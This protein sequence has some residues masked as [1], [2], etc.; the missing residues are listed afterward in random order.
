[1]ERDQGNMYV[2]EGIIISMIL[3]GAA[4][5]VQSLDSSSLENVRPRAEIG[6]LIDDALTVL[7][8]LDDGSGTRLLDRYLL[9]AM[10]CAYD[11]TPSTTDCELRRSKNLSIKLDSYLPLGGGYSIAL[12]NG[13]AVREIY[14]S[15]LPQGEAVGASRNFGPEWNTT[16]L[17]TEMSCYPA[18]TDV[19]A[20]LIPIAHGNLTYA[21]WANLTIGGVEYEGENASSARWWNATLAAGTRPVAGN[22]A[23]NVT[24]NDSLH[25][26]T[27]YA[28]C[29]HGG[30]TTQLHDQLKLATFRASASKVSVGGTL[31]FEADLTPLAAIAGVTIGASNVTLFEPLPNRSAGPDTWIRAADAVPMTGAVGARSAT[32]HAPTYALYGA[33]PALLRVSAT[34]GTTTFELRRAMVVDVALHTGEVPI[35]PP[36][37]ASLQGWLADWG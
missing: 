37:R 1:M 31:G 27:Q 32:Y 7:A 20:T 14:R 22:V 36:Y 11:E 28:E 30:L 3:L 15:P 34:I 5:A 9:E 21:R 19:N 18:G 26:L 35:D 6:R 4:Y 16:F 17:F 33:H 10:H 25:G 29:D 23:A 12:G 2:L 24:G 13:A 8:G